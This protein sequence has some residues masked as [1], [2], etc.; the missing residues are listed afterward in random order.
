MTFQAI[1]LLP[2]AR[3]VN[4]PRST[5]GLEPPAL[6]DPEPFTSSAPN[7]IDLA[8]IGS[9]LYSSYL[10]SRVPACSSTSVPSNHTGEPTDHAYARLGLICPA[11]KSGGWRARRDRAYGPNKRVEGMMAGDRFFVTVFA[12]DRAAL[13]QLADFDLDL[14]QATA[15]A[16]DEGEEP[17]IEGLLSLEEIGRL[18]EAGYRVAVEA[19]ESSRSRAA[20]QVVQAQDFLKSM[21]M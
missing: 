8:D 18:V 19:T 13:R 10:Y 17:R 1:R 6:D 7:S 12:R 5:R 21:G 9:Y 3:S 4:R 15:R 20:E 16:G 14:F 2:D 11:E